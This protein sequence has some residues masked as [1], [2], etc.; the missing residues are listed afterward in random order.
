[1]V[2]S[3][4]EDDGIGLSMVD[5]YHGHN[6][7]AEGLTTFRYTDE[8]FTRY[9]TQTK[10]IGNFSVSTIAPTRL[11]DGTLCSAPHT[12]PLEEGTQYI[13]AA[14]KTGGVIQS[15]CDT[16]WNQALASLGADLSAQISQVVLPSKPD[17]AT[18]VVKVDNVRSSSWTYVPANNSVKFSAGSVPQKG[19]NIVIGYVE[20]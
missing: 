12:Q 15:I 1:M 10:G 7:L 20:R 9:L 14:K 19:A 3:D 2:V 16:N 6:F 11:S 4:E 17:P 5:A 18:L 8:D 13:A